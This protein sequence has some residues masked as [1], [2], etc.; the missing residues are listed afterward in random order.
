MLEVTQ[1]GDITRLKMGREVGDNAP[2]LE[3]KEVYYWT[4][5]YLVDGLLIDT[6]CSYTVEEL[7]QFLEGEHLKFAI[8]THFHEDHIAANSVLQKKFGLKIYASRE[9]I[10][11]IKKM[12]KLPQYQEIVWGYPVPTEVDL[13]P[14][15]LE[16]EHYSFDVIDTPGHC[17][18]HVALIERTEGWCFSGDLYV[19]P[20]PKAIWSGEDMAEVTR[21]M[22]KLIE[23]PTD[24]L[25]LFTS[26]GLVVPDGREALQACVRFLEESARRA[27]EL[28]RQG[29]S[30]AAIRDELFG[31][32]SI[33][34]SVTEG[35]VSAE[36]M[37]RALLRANI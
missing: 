12:P 1:F 31:R 17:E 29:L 7:A 37:V 36:N 27:K 5:A 11:L 22:K 35:D 3:G 34:A 32:E 18:G 19:S 23:Y 28:A 33:L 9:S 21:S 15:R 24:K 16:T 30:I 2:L 20:E 14:R 13:I 10:P 4:A 25:T 6:G 8:N 26:L